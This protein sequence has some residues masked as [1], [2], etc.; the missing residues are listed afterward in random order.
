[1]VQLFFYRSPVLLRFMR[2]ALL[3]LVTSCG[4]DPTSTNATKLSGRANFPTSLGGGPLANTEYQVIDLERP[5]EDRIVFIGRTDDL[6]S[7]AASIRPTSSAAVIVT[8]I[9]QDT[10]VPISGLVNPSELEVFKNFEGITTIA[11]FAGVFAIDDGSITA[12]QLDEQRI[13]NL[14]LAAA[15]FVDTTNFLDQ[16]SINAAANM[17]RQITND[18]AHPPP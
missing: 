4:S 6:G 5:V 18:G 2:I 15:D 12:Q 17:V 1:M 9:S 14:E 3:F 13:R 7:Y 11:C 8:G 10:P 16:N